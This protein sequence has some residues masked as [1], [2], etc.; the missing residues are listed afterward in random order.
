MET[1]RFTFDSMLINWQGFNY[2][3][4]NGEPFP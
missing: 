4:F 1:L 2:N 3:L